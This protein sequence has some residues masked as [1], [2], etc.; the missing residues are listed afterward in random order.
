MVRYGNVRYVVRCNIHVSFR[1]RRRFPDHSRCWY[2][3]PHLPSR[4]NM[5][6]SRPTQGLGR[7]SPT[8][9][10]PDARMV[11]FQVCCARPRLRLRSCYSRNI[12]PSFH[13]PAICPLASS[14]IPSSTSP[15]SLP[16]YNPL[17]SAHSLTTPYPVVYR[18]VKCFIHTSDNVRSSTM[19]HFLRCVFSQFHTAV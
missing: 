1:S 7:M 5:S 9:T 3:F 15:L 18:N 10:N 12:P 8:T 19:C 4:R 6:C 11:W 16:F 2:I 13:P 14:P 17:L